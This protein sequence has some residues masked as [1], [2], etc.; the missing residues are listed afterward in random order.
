MSHPLV[1]PDLVGAFRADGAVVVRG[2]FA[3]FVDDIRVGIERNLAAPGPHA[4]LPIP[5]PD[6]EGME[7]RE[8]AMKPGDA[9]REDRLPALH[10]ATRPAR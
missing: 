1:P 3:D 9:P 8:S 2:L 5:D 6:A 10:D 7:G 4:G